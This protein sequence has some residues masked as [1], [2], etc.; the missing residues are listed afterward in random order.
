MQKLMNAAQRKQVL[1]IAQYSNVLVMQ[2]VNQKKVGVY[3]EGG[4]GPN[5]SEKG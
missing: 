2:T 1:A 4:G 3:T 5:G